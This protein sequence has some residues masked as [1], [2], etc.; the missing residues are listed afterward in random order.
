MQGACSNQSVKCIIYTSDIEI[1]INKLLEIENEK[2]ESGIETVFKHI[3]KSTYISSEIRFSDGEEWIIINP[4]AGARGY[5]WRKA[6]VDANNTTIYQLYLNIVTY[7]SGYQWED[8][9]LFNL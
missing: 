3:S 9:K 2:N 8:Y 7:G 6:W 5:R 1:G 4:N